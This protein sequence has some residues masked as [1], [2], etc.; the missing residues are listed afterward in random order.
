MKTYKKRLFQVTS[1][2]TGLLIGFLI[3]EVIFRLA[4]SPKKQPN[5]EYFQKEGYYV[6]A[7]YKK[8]TSLNEKGDTINVNIDENG[9]RNGK[10]TLK[11][12]RIILLGDSYVFGENTPQEKTLAALMEKKFCHV[13]N[14]GMNGFSTFHSLRLLKDLL[15][16]SHPHRVILCVYLGNDF[17]DNYFEDTPAGK[18]ISAS[19]A[20]GSAAVQQAS[21]PPRKG[22]KNSVTSML[23]QSRLLVFLV[24]RL[25][26][27]A[28]G[29]GD[30]MTNYCISE[31]ESYRLSYKAPMRSA[32]E[33]TRLAISEMADLL[34]KEH[35]SFLV[36]G[37]PSKA[38][39]AKSFKEI[40]KYEC[41]LQ[42]S[43]KLACE[44]LCSGFSFD[45]PDEALREITLEKGIP[46][47]SLLSRFRASGVE[48]IYCYIDSHWNPEGQQA[49]AEDLGKRIGKEK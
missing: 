7:P 2:V 48:H 34:E 6:Y 44:L 45:R 29:S 32:Q 16:H 11:D 22:I 42:A 8:F 31:M 13:Y 18:T 20:P 33:K 46:Y 10:D 5:S 21:P 41:D 27:L 28:R 14:A 17:H 15:K 4:D 35:I 1:V 43:S 3:C 49:A 30:P 36:M 39:V 19:A 26:L 47:L 23:K 12:A 37:I 25:K 38:Q 9:L 40:S 24:S